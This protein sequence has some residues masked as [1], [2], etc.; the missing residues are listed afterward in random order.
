MLP[1]ISP[2]DI[3]EPSS[4]TPMTY[5]P[6]GEL[7]AFATQSHHVVI[8]EGKLDILKER[9][10]VVACVAIHKEPITSLCWDPQ[11]HF[12]FL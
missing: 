2:N 5:S 9:E 1:L 12:F 10:R 6:N 4:S 3:I 8:L 11:A 7:V